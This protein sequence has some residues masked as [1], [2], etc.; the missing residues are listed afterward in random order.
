MTSTTSTMALRLPDEIEHG[1]SSI[2]GGG[3]RQS[4]EDLQ[5]VAQGGHCPPTRAAP[6]NTR[7][8]RSK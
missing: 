8:P 4:V 7:R 3:E 1:E 2:V 6:A 5:Q